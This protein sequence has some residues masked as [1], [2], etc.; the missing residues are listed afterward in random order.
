MDGATSANFASSSRLGRFLV[1]PIAA[2]NCRQRSYAPLF[3]RTRP[4]R[5][6]CGAEVWSGCQGW[7][8]MFQQASRN[9]FRRMSMQLARPTV[10]GGGCLQIPGSRQA[11]IILSHTGASEATARV[12][13]LFRIVFLIITVNINITD[14]PVF[15]F[16]AALRIPHVS[17]AFLA[18][19]DAPIQPEKRG[20]FSACSSPGRP[21]MSTSSFI[22]NCRQT[23][24]QPPIPYIHVQNPLAPH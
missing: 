7:E 10:A 23:Q 14:K 16:L 6:R 24:S 9:R 4:Q 15:I 5:E 17:L 3:K 21:E 11:A 18:C 22:E 20:D 1:V 12:F 13:S 8:R 2:A 19:D